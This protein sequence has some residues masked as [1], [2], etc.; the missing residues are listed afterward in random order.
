LGV[1]T[2]KSG[3][4]VELAAYLELKNLN[5]VRRRIET[6]IFSLRHGMPMPTCWRLPTAYC[7]LPHTSSGTT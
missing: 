4:S 7:L 1:V 6:G 3:S 5:N 2:G